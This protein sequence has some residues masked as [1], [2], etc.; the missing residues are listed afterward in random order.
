[1]IDLDDVH[2][3]AFAYYPRLQKVRDHLEQHLEDEISLATAAQVAGLG[4]KYFSTYFREKTGIRFKDWFAHVR[5]KRAAEIMRSAE[6]TITSTAFAVGFQDLST[7]ERACRKW[8]GMTARAYKK[9]VQ[10][11]RTARLDS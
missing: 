2:G 6:H 4:E 9:S 10:P 8:M 5:V 1:M 7:L 3:K 11:T